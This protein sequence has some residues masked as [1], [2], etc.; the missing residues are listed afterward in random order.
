M[1]ALYRKDRDGSIQLA[2]I[3]GRAILGLDPGTVTGWALHLP[4]RL[5]KSGTVTLPNIP[6]DA[7]ARGKKPRSLWEFLDAR[8]KQAGGLHAVYFELSQFQARGTGPL[9]LMD[10]GALYEII[11][12]W[13]F[14]PGIPTFGVA[15]QTIKKFVTGSGNAKKNDVKF[16]V[17]AW[18]FDPKSY[19]EAD[20]IGVLSY[21]L[22]QQRR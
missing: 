4:S 7:S 15:P 9:S 18:G 5:V 12:L 16:A 20:A 10:R 14:L 13:A 22:E 3:E 19:D 21:G 2:G 1:Q 11:R 8:N 6:V 17:E